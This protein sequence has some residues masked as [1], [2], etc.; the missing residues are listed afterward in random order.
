FY[1]QV[2]KKR[3][4]LQIDQELGLDKS[5]TGIVSRLAADNAEFQRSFAR[6]M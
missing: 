6:A 5:S 4:I 2:L 1:S 3:G